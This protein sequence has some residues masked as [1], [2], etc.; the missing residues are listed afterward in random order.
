M[1]FC[2]SWNF[3][4]YRFKVFFFIFQQFSCEMLKYNFF[5]GWVYGSFFIKLK[6]FSAIIFKERL[7]PAPTLL[8]SSWTQLHIRQLDILR[9]CSI[10]PNLFSLSFSLDRVKYL[11]LYLSKFLAGVPVIR[12][13]KAYKFT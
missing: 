2:I 1:F 9:V 13:I 12:Q 6:K 8:S 11:F 10:L 5:L 4:G 3:L 7:F